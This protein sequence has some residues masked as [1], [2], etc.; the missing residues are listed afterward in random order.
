MFEP[1]CCPASN[2]LATNIYHPNTSRTGQELL[3]RNR[4]NACMA[5]GAHAEAEEAFAA[6]RTQ[7]QHSGN[8]LNQ[9]KA[10]RGMPRTRCE[11][12]C[13]PGLEAP[14]ANE[15]A[16]FIAQLEPGLLHRHLHRT[17]RRVHTV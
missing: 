16:A 8:R 3:L 17:P 13:T 6:M 5:A 10:L 12:G 1:F 11:R 15:L 7:A 14:E 4:A 2:D 9:I